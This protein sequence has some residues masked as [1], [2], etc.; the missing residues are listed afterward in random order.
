M[1]DQAASGWHFAFTRDLDLIR[2]AVTHERVYGR[3]TD[4][5]SPAADAFQPP[6]YCQYVAV[7]QSDEFCGIFVLSPH[8][9]IL[10]EVHTALLP[11]A[12]GDSADIG[13]AFIQWLFS[14]TP[15]RRLITA[16]PEYNRLALRMAK[17]TG[18]AEYG[19]NPAS[20]L[21]NGKLH[22]QIML[23]VSKEQ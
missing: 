1:A 7:Y 2:P 18:M 17:S 22:D 6:E 21:K 19:V 8:N 10:T 14:N 15:T 11:T 23:G 16:V 12:W 13:R 9:G 3:T 20:F 4:D 5:L